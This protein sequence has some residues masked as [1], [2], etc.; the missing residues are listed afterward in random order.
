[1]SLWDVITFQSPIKAAEAQNAGAR[2]AEGAIQQYGKQ[3]QEYQQPYYDT[4]TGAMR[5]LGEKVQSGQYEYNPQFNFQADPGYQW[6]M[7]EGTNAINNNAAA[8]GLR[9]SG[10]TQKALQRYGQ[11]LAN[12]T[13]QQAYNR[14]AD[15]RN[16]GAQQRQ[17]QY[18]RMAGLAGM[19]QTASQ[20]MSNQANTQ[21]QNL[22][23][24]YGSMGA[25]TAAG[26]MG[27]AQQ[28]G[29]VLGGIAKLGG[30]LGGAALMGPAVGSLGG[31][32][33]KAATAGERML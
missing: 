26:I 21:G 32:F 16:Y 28:F 9:L 22:A 29:N 23:N 12:Q 11:G 5:S 6:Q 7:Q 25:N 31:I 33:G 8:S 30:T 18:N 3:A 10:A 1:M 14:F 2:R 17:D 19:G 13:Y 27:Q 4:G 15:T 24:L 20:Y